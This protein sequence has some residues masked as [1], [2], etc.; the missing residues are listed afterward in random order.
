MTTPKKAQNYACNGLADSI[1]GDASSFGCEPLIEIRFFSRL[2]VG[3][4]SIGD[5]IRIPPVGGGFVEAT[6]ARFTED[7]T[8]EWVGLPLCDTVRAEPRPFCICVDGRPVGQNLIKVPS[9]LEKHSEHGDGRA[10][11]MR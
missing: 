5:T 9:Q 6:V 8:D 4:L 7:L 1:L 10:I 2:C 3:E 11:T